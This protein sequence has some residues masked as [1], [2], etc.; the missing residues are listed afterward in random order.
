M[1][2][3]ITPERG[4]DIAAKLNQ[5]FETMDDGAGTPPEPA[6]KKV[7]PKNPVPRP[8]PQPPKPTKDEAKASKREAKREE[9][10]FA[11]V[12][13]PKGRR[14]RRGWKLLAA[15][16][17][18]AALVS[19]GAW[20]YFSKD[21]LLKHGENPAL[22]GPVASADPAASL[23]AEA[24]VV[25]LGPPPVGDASNPAQMTAPVRDGDLSF[26]VTGA[27][28]G[29]PG[30]FGRPATVDLTVTN[31]A[32]VPLPLDVL[33]QNVVNDS[34]SL[35]PPDPVNSIGVPEAILPGETAVM[36]LAYMLPPNETPD[37][38]NLRGIPASQGVFVK[39]VP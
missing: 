29:E 7:L 23:P 28:V 9:A 30:E 11:D 20:A 27:N 39:L 32:T 18:L 35:V 33:Q 16:A 31:L 4:R 17:T 13:V 1:T 36:T 26:V 34:G 14:A 3:P 10:L 19:A 8:A 25:P 21:N 38:M 37:S 12:T 22:P 5:M 24:Q 6:A 2:D 15:L